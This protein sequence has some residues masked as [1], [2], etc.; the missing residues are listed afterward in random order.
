MIK[1]E[2]FTLLELMIVIII[3]GILAALAIPR[4]ITLTEKAKG[5]EAITNCGIL[6]NSELRYFAEYDTYTANIASLDIEDPN[7]VPTP[8]RLFDYTVPSAGTDEDSL[9]VR[10]ARNSG[11]HSGQY[12]EIDYQGT[13]SGDWPWLPR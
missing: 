7:N 11:T 9:L 6:R 13:W 10:A 3:I 5:A 12:I 8:K 1:R 4:Y 2:G